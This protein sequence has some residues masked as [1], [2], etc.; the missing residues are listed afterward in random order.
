M[1]RLVAQQ[2]LLVQEHRTRSNHVVSDPCPCVSESLRQTYSKEGEAAKQPIG[3]QTPAA[4]SVAEG[5]AQ[6]S[7]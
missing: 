2:Q 4:A 6:T 5:S 7:S 3:F 1:N